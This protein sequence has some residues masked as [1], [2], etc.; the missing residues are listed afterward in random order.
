MKGTVKYKAFI[1]VL[2]FPTVSIVITLSAPRPQSPQ[3]YLSVVVACKGNSH[4]LCHW[5]SILGLRSDNSSVIT[6]VKQTIPFVSQ[7]SPSQFTSPHCVV[8]AVC[9]V[10][11]HSIKYRNLYAQIRRSLNA[12]PLPKRSAKISLHISEIHG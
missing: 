3:Y 10:G 5:V 1:F 12:E 11:K 8:D 2:L 7:P 9:C 6:T 4:L